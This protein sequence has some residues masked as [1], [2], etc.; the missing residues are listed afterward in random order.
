MM[1]K[2]CGVVKT[3]EEWLE[4]KIVEN[5]LELLDAEIPRYK[6]K[7]N[8]VHMCFSTDPFMYEQDPVSELSIQIIDKLNQAEKPCSTLTKGLYPRE[9]AKRNGKSKNN[10]YGITLVS[11][12][13]NFRKK[14][15]PNTSAFKDRIKSL[16]YLHDNG[17]KTWV[18]MEPY[19]TPNFI[20]QNLKEILEAVDFV[21]QIVFGK[22]N[23][24]AEVSVFKYH[25]EYYNS[26]A[27][28]FVG[29]CKK[30]DIKYYVKEGTVTSKVKYID[31]KVHRELCTSKI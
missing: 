28:Y 6:N 12:D 3:Y 11:L 10:R 21:D 23:Y 9:L 26:L 4:P 2:R 17:L 20:E 5:A 14:Y 8:Y 7:I 29:F 31:D 22:L 30:N 18:S 1:K 24:N 15:E 27:D 16:K 13:E 25:K 19:P